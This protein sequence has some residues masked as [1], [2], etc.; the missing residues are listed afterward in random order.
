MN[1]SLVEIQVEQVE[2]AIYLIRGERVMLDRDLALLYG[3][4]TKVFNQAVKR[5]A[6]R[7]PSDFMFQLTMDEAR[8]VRSR[9]QSV[10]FE[11]VART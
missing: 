10:T 4:S 9:S 1:K 2:K 6:E 5:R 7:F 8:A 11:S 3:V